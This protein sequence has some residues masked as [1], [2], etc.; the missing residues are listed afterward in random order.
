MWCG[1]WAPINPTRQE[2]SG[3]T[4]GR[5]PATQPGIAQALH[6]SAEELPV[7]GAPLRFPHPE[8]LLSLMLRPAIR[9]LCPKEQSPIAALNFFDDTQADTD[10]ATPLKAGRFEAIWGKPIAGHGYAVNPHPRTGATGSEPAAI[11]H[12]LSAARILVGAA[13]HPV[14]DLHKIATTAKGKALTRSKFAR[15]LTPIRLLRNRI[16]TSMPSPWGQSSGRW[17]RHHTRYPP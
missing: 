2:W 16:A 10:P 1:V 17:V 7:S 11:L 13:T 8:H 3:S 9:Y 12:R 4:W 5:R 15:D 14:S 6:G